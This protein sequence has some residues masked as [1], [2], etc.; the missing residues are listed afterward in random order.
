MSNFPTLPHAKR[1]H[2]LTPVQRADILDL[3]LSGVHEREIA[4]RYG[5]HPD[6]VRVAAQRA[7]V[8][9]KRPGD[10]K[11]PDPKAEQL[12]VWRAKRSLI[13]AAGC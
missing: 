1:T 12:P 10:V 9:R 5:L 2:K 11:L 8:S 7:G 6:Y 3:Y 13:K 4:A